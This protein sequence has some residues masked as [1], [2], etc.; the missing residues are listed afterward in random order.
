MKYTWFVVNS[1]GETAGCN[2]QEW[3]AKDLAKRMQELEPT[4]GWKAYDKN[5][6]KLK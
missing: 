2:L 4:A 1:K 3:V 6:E 5:K